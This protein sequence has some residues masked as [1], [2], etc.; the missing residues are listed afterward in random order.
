MATIC[1]NEDQEELKVKTRRISRR[2][3]KYFTASGEYNFSTGNW[4]CE[5]IRKLDLC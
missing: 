2:A 5:M 1:G 4:Q 3:K